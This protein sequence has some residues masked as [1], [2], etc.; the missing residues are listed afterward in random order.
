MLEIAIRDAVDNDE[1]IN[2]NGT[3]NWSFVD[4][5]A[6]AECRSFWKDDVDFYEAFDEIANKITAEQMEENT[7]AQ[8]EMDFDLLDR[9]PNAIE[10]LEVL[11]TDFLGL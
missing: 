5:D 6:Y 7:N 10:Q 8:I 11:K 9:Y 1:N 3:I 4:A 2:D